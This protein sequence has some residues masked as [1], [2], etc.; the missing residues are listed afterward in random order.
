MSSNGK[1]RSFRDYSAEEG[2]SD[3]NSNKRQTTLKA[4]YRRYSSR[5][6]SRWPDLLQ[7]L[8]NQLLAHGISYLNKPAEVAAIK[9]DPPEPVFSVFRATTAKPNEEPHEKEVRDM[10]NDVK[11]KLY[12][13]ALS[14]QI[15]KL[16]RLQQDNETRLSILYDLVDKTIHDELH[17]FKKRACAEMT[18]EEQFN[19]V[20]QHLQMT[21]GPHSSLDVRELTQQLSDLSPITSG[22]PKYLLAF[23]HHVTTTLADMKQTDPTSGAVLRGPKPAPRKVNHIPLTG[24]AAQDAAILMAHYLATRDEQAKKVDREWPDGGPELNHKP[25]NSSNTAISKIYADSLE[26][27][28]WTWTTIFDKIKIVSDNLNDGL[29]NGKGPSTPSSKHSSATTSPS[30]TSAM[31]S[32][33]R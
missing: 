7:S 30:D 33:I 23:S 8:D 14:R 20:F 12:T 15:T 9:A 19:A 31:N 25:Q 21:H 2:R 17:D 29:H 11:K 6:K 13:D 32:I 3:K 27:P 16:E 1:K 4:G 5:D 24:D 18:P 26:K 28:D 22:W 10:K